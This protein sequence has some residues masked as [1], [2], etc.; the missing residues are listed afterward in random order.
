MPDARCQRP[1]ARCQMADGGWRMANGQLQ[2]GSSG[3]RTH[4]RVDGGWACRVRGLV[5][6]IPFVRDDSR[7]RKTRL[8]IERPR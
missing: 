2:G 7:G 5:G 3:A 6:L 4:G 1:E 8:T